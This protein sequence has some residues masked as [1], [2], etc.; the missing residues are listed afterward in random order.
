MIL[1]DEAWEDFELQRIGG[2]V[3][4]LENEREDE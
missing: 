3:R 2:R 1:K 4:K